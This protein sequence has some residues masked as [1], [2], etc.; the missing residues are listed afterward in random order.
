MTAGASIT[1]AQPQPYQRPTYPEAPAYFGEALE[2]AERLLKYAAEMGIPI[3]DDTRDHILQA[4]MGSS[5]GWDEETAAAL[6]IALGRLAAKLKPVT[7]ES[8]KARNARPTLRNYWIVS[9][10]LAVI[11][12]LFSAASFVASAL[13]GAIKTDVQ[14]ANDLAVKLRAQLGPPPQEQRKAAPLGN[15]T[16]T[17]AAT[18]PG[19]VDVITEL[20]QYATDIRAIYGRARQLRVL[21]F[22]AETDPFALDRKD[23]VKMHN[24]LQLPEGLADF[25]WAAGDRT[26]KYQDLRYYAQSLVDDVAFYY[27]A[28]S[29]CVLPVLYALLGTC[30][31]MLRTFEQQM[32]S[33]T[34]AP[35]MANSA[36]FLIAIIGGAVVGLFNNFA[37]GQGVSIPQL[38][39]AFLVGYSVDVFFAFL[40]G[41][42]QTITR[43]RAGSSTPPASDGGKA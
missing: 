12:V 30:A 37:I 19:D 25:A 27:G 21:A 3:E 31:F 7:A 18:N 4:R 13:S 38:A 29:A 26:K 9:I 5:A 17:N 24:N 20:Q 2:D 40:E 43:G 1:M 22:G 8:L 35:S 34:F 11:V 41:T 6:L 32:A 15:A 39:I 28:I 23:T 16:Q 33:R 14:L 42:L 36:R 10:C